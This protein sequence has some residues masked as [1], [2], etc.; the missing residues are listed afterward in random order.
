MREVYEVACIVLTLFSIILLVAGAYAILGRGLVLPM[1]TGLGYEYVSPTVRRRLQRIY[2]AGLSVVGF[3]DT[4]L[5]FTMG[6]NLDTC[7]L[8]FVISVFGLLVMM[9]VSTIYGERL[10]E[11]TL[12]SMPLESLEEVCPITPPQ[13]SSITISLIAISSA[14]IVASIAL[15]PFLPDNIVL[16]FRIDGTPGTPMPS[17][18]VY[19]D[20][21]PLALSLVMASSTLCTLLVKKPEAF[22]RPVN[23]RDTMKAA[24]LTCNFLSMASLVVSTSLFFVTLYNVAPMMR[25]AVQAFIVFTLCL[26]TVTMFFACAAIYTYFKVLKA[27]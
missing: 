20:I 11:R 16:N 23:G 7:V 12:I 15:M 4:V 3:L 2:G 13:S 8:I 10:A 14:F 19:R 9:L 18:I 17:S 26:T 5:A 27:C 25:I 1:A 24:L 21:L 22:H 6:F